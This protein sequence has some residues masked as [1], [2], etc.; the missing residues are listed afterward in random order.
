MVR[1]ISTFVRSPAVDEGKWKVSAQGGS[2]PVWSA[3]GDELFFMV[4]NSLMSAPVST[5][6]TFR[7]G[8]PT[9][10]FQGRQ[11]IQEAP[12]FNSFDFEP[13]SGRFLM[14][15]PGSADDGDS[16]A[17]LNLTVVFNWFEEL[18]ETVPNGLGE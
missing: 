11:M 5:E 6:Q 7:S 1:R 12:I 2:H 14:R 10:V 17:P 8:N 15:Q 18:S 9:V 4:G 16:F 3:S 13:G